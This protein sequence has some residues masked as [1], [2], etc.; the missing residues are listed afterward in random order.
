M[1]TSN[2]MPCVNYYENVYDAKS[3]LDLII[4]ESKTDWPRLSWERSTV[5]GGDNE[6]IVSEYRSSMSM[7]LQPITTQE[8]LVEN[9][10][11]IKK[12]FL[13]IWEK[14]NQLVWDYR[15]S[16][17]LHLNSDEGFAVLRYSEGAEY[18]FH[19][20]AD[21]VNGRQ[22]SMVAY[23]NDEYEGGELEFP[24]FDCKIKP[25]AGSVIFFPSSY[26]YSHIAHPVTNGIKYSMV[27]W[28]K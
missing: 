18:H 26:A 23:L 17:K 10:E 20:D 25:T 8:E 12:S 9:L 1:K 7:S 24:Y 3:F 2:P 13:E 28:F 19:A 27:T 15:D 22:M 5:G 4:Q 6:S 14:I 11:E 21:S 16:Y